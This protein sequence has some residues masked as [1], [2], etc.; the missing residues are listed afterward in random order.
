MPHSA[1]LLAGK[2]VDKQLDLGAD[3]IAYRFVKKDT[4]E[5]VIAAWS[6]GDGLTI[7]L[8]CD[9]PSTVV[10]LMDE[11]R[12]V[13]P[14]DGKVQLSLQRDAPVFCGQGPSS[15]SRLAGWIVLPFITAAKRSQISQ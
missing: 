13:E 7:E 2:S 9:A 15:G 5:A 11:R 6:S 1:R 4:A 10:N 14:V 3:V 8:P 12:M